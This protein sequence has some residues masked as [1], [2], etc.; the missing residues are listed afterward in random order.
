MLRLS[1]AAVAALVALMAASSV[2]QAQAPKA[3]P[4]AQQKAGAPAQ[5]LPPP[6][7]LAAAK[8]ILILKNASSVYQGAVVSTLQNVKN[9]LLQS[10]INLQRDI[11]EVSL[12]LARDL[13]N[14]ESEIGEGMAVIYATNFTEQELKDLLAFYKTP[15]GKKTLEAEPK[16]IEESLNFLRNWGEDFAQEVNVRFRDEM[17]KRGKDL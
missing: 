15:L 8:E 13:G 17:K 11:E 4:A 3:P 12:K 10:N 9:A 6:G 14:R 2:A 5:I 1:V 7:A 16:S